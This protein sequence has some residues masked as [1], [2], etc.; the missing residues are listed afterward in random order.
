MLQ[1]KTMKKAEA[2]KAVDTNNKKEDRQ[3]GA[4]NDAPDNN[5]TNNTDDL[6]LRPCVG[7]TLFNHQGKVFVGERIDNQGAWQMPQGGIDEGEEATEAF[8]RELLEEAGIESHH[9]DILKVHDK[10]LS[11]QLPPH[12]MGRL[13]N[14][15]WGGQEQTWIAARFTGDDSDI[16]IYYYR[17]PEFNR[18]K[19]V[20]LDE[21]LDLIVPFKR[22]TYL[23]VVEA[24]REFESVS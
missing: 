17:F 6:P 5:S 4:T 12:L 2:V 24:F 13:W 19:W 16:N 10:K 9:V 21:M 20:A 18:W 3:G 22:N 23:E 8:Y 1:A 15:K 11:Y 7:I 14:G